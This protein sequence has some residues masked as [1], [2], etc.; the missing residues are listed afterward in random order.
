[1]AMCTDL[2]Q[3]LLAMGAAVVGLKMGESGMYLRTTTDPE[4][5]SPL[6]GTAG[7]AFLSWV[8]RE[9]HA[10]CFEVEVAGTTGCG[11][12]AVAGF[13]A[14][15]LR[16]LTI[17]DALTMAVAAGACCAEAA[18]A[19]SGVKPWEDTRQRIGAGWSRRTVPQACPEWSV[20]DSGPTG[21]R[22]G[23]PSL[24]RGPNDASCR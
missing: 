13:L 9:L 12:S 5:L 7:E 6:A 17:E 10:S 19:I 20:D 15:L 18:D 23:S 1:M 4:R 11:D 21:C 24:R 16:G 2:S 8:G 22:N 14:G 3:E